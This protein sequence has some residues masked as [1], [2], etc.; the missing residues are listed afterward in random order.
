MFPS[1]SRGLAGLLICLF[2]LVML[3]ACGQK[4]DLYHSDDEQQSSLVIIPSTV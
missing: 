3:S 4:G 2:M 1:L